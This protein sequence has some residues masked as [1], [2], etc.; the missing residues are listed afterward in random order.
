[1]KKKDLSSFKSKPQKSL[2][3]IYDSKNNK[4]KKRSKFYKI[5]NKLENDFENNFIN[6]FDNFNL[7]FSQRTFVNDDEKERFRSFFVNHSTEDIIINFRKYYCFII[8]NFDNI[9]NIV[10][11]KIES[12]EYKKNNGSFFFS[13]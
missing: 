9:I 13:L 4:I 7:N 10:S 8:N 2:D 12:E 1:M 6:Y 5:L 3:A 11:N